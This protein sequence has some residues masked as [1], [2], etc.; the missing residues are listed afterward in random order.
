MC[1]PP[2]T[3]FVP[4]RSRDESLQSAI[5]NINLRIPY[6]TLLYVLDGVAVPPMGRDNFEG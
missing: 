5:Q 4:E 6:F 3:R 2:L 1:D